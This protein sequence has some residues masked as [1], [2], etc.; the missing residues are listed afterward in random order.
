MKKDDKK[1]IDYTSTD[2]TIL[3]DGQLS[4]EKPK[5]DMTYAAKSAMQLKEVVRKNKWIT[6]IQGKEHL[7]FEA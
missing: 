2:I 3:G 1:T 7:S 5:E 6:N 4:L